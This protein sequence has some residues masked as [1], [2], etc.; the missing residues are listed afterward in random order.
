MRSV[1]RSHR[2]ERDESGVTLILALAIMVGV[3]LALLGLVGFAGNSLVS[4]ASFRSQR[5][6]EY[7]ANAATDVAV[8]NV[9]FLPTT[10]T[11]ST[12]CL[13]F[14]ASQVTVDGYS[15]AVTC[16]GTTNPNPL[17]TNPVTR[18][19]TFYTCQTAPCTSSN[20]VVQAVVSFEDYSSAGSL[21]CAPT[22]SVSCGTGMI[23]NQWLV[24]SANS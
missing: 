15:F 20:A 22:S 2:S 14:G 13:L 5:S 23:V 3:S 8:Q 21:S 10:Y 7:A 16:T 19:V 4:T 24:T 9:R 11:T 12:A 17:S 18:Q 1:T 6:F